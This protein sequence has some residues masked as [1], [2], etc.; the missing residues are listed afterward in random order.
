MMGSRIGGQDRFFYDFNLDERIPQD[1]LLR[2][3]DGVVDFSD[4]RQ[5][6]A[7]YYSHTGRP[8]VDP[9]LMVRML[10]IGYCYGIRSE[11]RLCE[12][13][14]LNL[15][16]RWFCRMGL[17]DPVPDHSTFSKNRHGRFRDADLLRYVFDR[18]VQRCYE[19]G[20]VAGEGFA[21]DASYIKADA[22]RQ[23]MVDGPVDW[24]PSPTQSRAVREYLDALDNEPLAR[25]TQKKVSVTD[26]MAQWAG[27]KG[28]AE[29]YY[30]TN[31][32]ID[33]EHNIILDVEPTPAHRTAEVTSTRTMIDRVE[34]KLAIKPKRLIADTG[35]GSAAM[36]D[37]VVEKKQIEP[38]IPVWD[39]SQGKPGI[40]GRTD[41]IW[42][43]EGGCYRCPAGN[44]LESRRRNFKRLHSTVT[45]ANTII[46]RS[47]QIDCR[48]CELK[49]R[50][51]PNT[52]FRKIAR[53]LYESSRD[54]AR[55]IS[56]SQAYQ[57]SRKDRKKVEVLFAHLKRIMN[58]DRLR[59]RG[60]TGAHDEFL[61]AATA[62]NLKKL[63]QLRY[64]PPDLE[65]GPPVLC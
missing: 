7:P 13:V 62:Q 35:Y 54:A 15:A 51:C 49:T 63:A 24:T 3:I 21:T 31:Y 9:E 45:K 14:N 17:E 34:T 26:P 47:S 40:F 10:V 56:Q 16:Y 20:L 2:Q 48:T 28:P 41:F 58:F 65:I 57:Q 46:Y 37:W 36:L 39:K 38:H 18:V 11:R 61:L 1:H 29:F 43:E 6:L 52:T 50:C 60:I 30:S 44:L 55:A 59:L 12:E 22:S 25:R 23:R 53:S 5:Q 33:V 32:L 19:E 8:S 27:D 4:I 64:K 42:D